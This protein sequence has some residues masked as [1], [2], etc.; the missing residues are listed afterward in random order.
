MNQ[1][2]VD[3][4]EATT[5]RSGVGSSLALRLDAISLSFGGVKALA[6]VHLAIAPGEI[7]AII[8]RNGAGKSLLLNVI[9]GIY[10]PDHGQF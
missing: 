6:D 3:L 10:Q 9:T 8:G 2:I 4:P 5:G 1:G 7:R